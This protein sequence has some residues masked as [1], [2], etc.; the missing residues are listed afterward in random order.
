MIQQRGDVK[1]VSSRN[2]RLPLQIRPGGRL[3]WQN[4]TTRYYWGGV[5]P[6]GIINQ[7]GSGTY[8][9]NASSGATPAVDGFRQG[10]CNVRV[11]DAATAGLGINSGGS[12]VDVTKEYTLM[13]R[14]ASGSTSNN[15][16]PGI[17]YCYDANCTTA[18]VSSSV[19]TNARVL[20]PVNYDGT[21]SATGD[22]QS[23]NA[24][25]TY[26]NGISCGCNVTGADWQVST[27]SS[28]TAT[29][30]FGLIF[31]A[32][33]RYSLSTTVAHPVTI[34]LL[35]N[36]VAAGNYVYFDDVILS[37][38]PVTP[39]LRLAPLHDSQNPTVYGSLGISQHLNQGAGNTFAGTVALPAG[40]ATVTFP[41]A[42]NSA[43]VSTAKDTSA[44]ATVRVQTSATALTLTQSSG[45]DTIAYICVGN[46]N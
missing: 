20:S 16:R 6:A 32:P 45:T 33:H 44:I 18:D 17:R 34:F 10:T 3:G 31:R 42:Y 23:T 29:R 14:V 1:R 38:G 37:Q 2:M 39:A 21:S 19:A 4:T 36:T 25:L 28:W 12:Q 40:T 27:A 30:I 13:F 26:H 8:V 35:E 43:P 15:F 7:V 46:P 11:G 24:S 41:T 5:T 9:Q 22:W